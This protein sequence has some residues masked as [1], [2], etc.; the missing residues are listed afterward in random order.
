MNPTP[1]PGATGN[2]GKPRGWDDTKATCSELQIRDELIPGTNTN[3]MVSY[4]KP[5]LEEIGLIGRGCPIVLKVVG[6]EHPP[7]S[8]TVEDLT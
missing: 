2:F 3:V 1:I 6:L 4:W 5:T 8:I 7:V